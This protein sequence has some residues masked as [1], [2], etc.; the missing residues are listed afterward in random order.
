MSLNK[1]TLAIASKENLQLKIFLY[2]PNLIG[3]LR[4]VCVL[5]A[6]WHFKTNYMVFI[7]SYVI[8]HILDAADGLAARHLNQCKGDD[9]SRQ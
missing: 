1:E 3:Y 7:I 5:I 8:S 9:K 6:F 4:F 2:V